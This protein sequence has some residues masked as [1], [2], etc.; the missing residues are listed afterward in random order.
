MVFLV[1]QIKLLL[2]AGAFRQHEQGHCCF[3][4][5]ALRRTHWISTMAGKVDG[6]EAGLLGFI[7]AVV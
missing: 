1:R 5:G 3:L 2:D 7:S 4:F 6:G